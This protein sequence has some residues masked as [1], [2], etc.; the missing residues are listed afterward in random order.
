MRDLHHTPTR[1]RIREYF[2]SLTPPIIIQAN[3]NVDTSNMTSKK[4]WRKS[5]RFGNCTVDRSVLFF[6]FSLRSHLDVFTFQISLAQTLQNLLCPHTSHS[7]THIQY[8]MSSLEFYLL[9]L[10]PPIWFRC[11][12]IDIHLLLVGLSFISTL[13]LFLSILSISIPTHTHYRQT[14]THQIICLSYTLSNQYHLAAAT[15]FGS[16]SPFTPECIHISDIF[17]ADSSHSPL[18]T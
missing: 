15:P 5:V 2:K 17:S 4:R 9:S 3:V 14:N 10:F 6:L 7:F 18:S 12:P 16:L 1:P 13:P 8:Q 11:L